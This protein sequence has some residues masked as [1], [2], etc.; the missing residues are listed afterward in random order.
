M[1][2]TCMQQISQSAYHE[3][4]REGPIVS[5]DSYKIGAAAQA[6]EFKSV[7]NGAGFRGTYHLTTHIQN[8]DLPG[9][10]FRWDMKVHMINSGIGVKMQ[11]TGYSQM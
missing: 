10:C 5:V 9:Q 6:I 2:V 11:V 8:A 7:F 1:G 4:S 3:L